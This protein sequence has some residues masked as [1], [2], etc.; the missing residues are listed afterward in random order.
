[1]LSDDTFDR[2]ARF[3]EVGN[4]LGRRRRKSP[5]LEKRRQYLTSFVAFSI[6]RF[7]A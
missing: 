5:R 6:N 3:A 2:R 1:M 4:S 7:E